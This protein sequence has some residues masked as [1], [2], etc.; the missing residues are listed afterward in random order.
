[1]H[2]FKLKKKSIK[3]AFA[4]DANKVNA[5]FESN[6]DKIDDAFLIKLGAYINQ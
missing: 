2:T 3:G 4:A 6:D 5:F 1:L